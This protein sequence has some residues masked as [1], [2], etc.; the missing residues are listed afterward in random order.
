[1]NKEN[2]AKMENEVEEDGAS[3]SVI[4]LNCYEKAAPKRI[5]ERLFS[6]SG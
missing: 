1:M 2:G 3:F 5:L 6:L 4:G